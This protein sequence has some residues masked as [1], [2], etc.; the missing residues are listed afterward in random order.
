MPQTPSLPPDVVFGDLQLAAPLDDFVI[1]KSDRWPT[2]HLASVVDDHYMAISH[3]LRGE[4]GDYLL[5]S[6]QFSKPDG[7]VSWEDMD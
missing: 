3:V 5:A 7:R 2:Y 4:V 1:V 6:V